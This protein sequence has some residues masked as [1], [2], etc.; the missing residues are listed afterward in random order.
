MLSRWAEE[1]LSQ[2][3]WSKMADWE[4]SWSWDLKDLDE[5]LTFPRPVTL[6]ESL[7]LTKF[8][9]LPLSKSRQ[10][11]ISIL[12]GRLRQKGEH[13]CPL[14]AAKW[15]QTWNCIITA[16]ELGSLASCIN[17]FLPPDTKRCVK[18]EVFWMIHK[19]L[20]EGVLWAWAA[21]SGSPL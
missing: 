2:L 9:N 15:L 11:N 3:E 17:S 16:E 19:H 12:V 4:E 20:P 8:Y 18:T 6:H 7:T 10:L 21:I 14:H 13:K 5:V 1:T